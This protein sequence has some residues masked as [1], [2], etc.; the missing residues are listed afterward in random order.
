[1]SNFDTEKNSIDSFLLKIVFYLN[2][3]LAFLISLFFL[4][5]TTEFYEFNK[6]ALI[7]GVTILSVVVLITRMLLGFKLDFIKSKLDLGIFALLVV[8]ILSTIFSVDKNLSIF[9]SEGRWF[10]SLI[11]FLILVT[12]Y[13]VTAPSLKNDAYIKTLIKAF[14]AGGS[15]SSLISILSFYGVYIFGYDFLKV[16]TFNT[17]G[18]INL[19][20]I[21]SVVSLF[22]TLGLLTYENNSINK[23]VLSVMAV[24]S[25]V[26]LCIANSFLGWAL[27]TFGLL[28]SLRFL[29]KELVIEKRNVV[30]FSVLAGI[31]L[32]VAALALIPQTKKII[33][34]GG[35]GYEITLPAKESWEI[36]ASTIK[37]SPLFGTGLSTFEFN[38]NR[39][40]P[41]DLNKTNLWGISFDKPQNEIFNTLTAMGIVGL[42]GVIVFGIKVYQAATKSLHIQDESGIAKILSLGILIVLFSFFFSYASVFGTFV[43]IMLLAFASAHYKNINTH[44]YAEIASLEFTSIANITSIDHENNK[45]VIK[46]SYIKYIAA[47][48]LAALILVASRSFYRIYAAEAYMHAS[49]MAF[50]D[51]NGAKVYEYQG[52]AINLNTRRSEYHREYAKTNLLLANSIASKKD[53]SDVDKQNIQSLIKESGNRAKIMTEVVGPLN[54]ANWETRG[55]IYRALDK[56]AKDSLQWSAAAYETAVQL[57]PANPILRVNLGGVYTAMG[58][59]LAAANQFKAAANLKPDY[60]NAKYNLAKALVALNEYELAK[61]ELLSVKS[62]L[63]A[64]SKD[65]E[66]LNTDLAMVEE[67][68]KTIDSNV[69]GAATEKP[70]IEELQKDAQ[71]ETTQQEPL[72]NVSQKSEIE[73]DNLNQDKLPQQ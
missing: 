14:V 55:A 7:T 63:P 2:I 62:L 52:K 5:T 66:T 34:K 12:Y 59:N 68:L 49:Q 41:A 25:F 39:F 32:G 37:R 70:T 35:Y 47:I 60:A 48:P 45:A 73:A 15:L 40:K 67:K 61:Q 51:G 43:L 6:L 69:A 71:K 11:G 65:L 29:F 9:G 31:F 56:V 8:V 58:N 72:T 3:A 18:S 26:Y 22:L 42:V 50:R 21:L 1:M 24:P 54:S 38:F 30:Y 27:L 19:A 23:I 64:D 4:P 46:G 17:L 57:S 28:V 53:L 33:F 20:T 13:Y 36:A 10:P 44:E 16:G